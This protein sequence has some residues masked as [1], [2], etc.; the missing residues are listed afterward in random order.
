MCV[1]LKFQKIKN[2]RKCKTVLGLVRH[3]HS[4]P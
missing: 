1:F 2:R 3:T 4:C